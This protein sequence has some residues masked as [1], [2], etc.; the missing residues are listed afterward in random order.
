[1][2]TPAFQQLAE[3]RRQSFDKLIDLHERLSQSVDPFMRYAAGWAAMYAAQKRGS[4]DSDAAQLL[5]EERWREINGKNVSIYYG[6]DPK[7]LHVQAKLALAMSDQLRYE[8]KLWTPRERQETARRIGELAHTHLGQMTGGD[9][10]MR[11]ELAEIACLQVLWRNHTI[12]HLPILNAVPAGP[13][14]DMRTGMI[15][16]YSTDIYAYRPGSS[17]QYKGANI[18]M[19]S[20]LRPQHKDRYGDI[21]VLIGATPDFRLP[22]GGNNGSSVR[23]IAYTTETCLDETYVRDQLP[24]PDAYALNASTQNV[25]S[26]TIR[27]IRQR[28]DLSA[29]NS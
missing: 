23:R 26:K 4:G 16:A 9:A 7:I 22:G 28:N 14:K 8:R 20:T 18:Q 24:E 10:R 3:G 27:T 5:A 1:M 29:D 21:M 25:I 11:G 13:A 6:E 12:D 15:S 17:K 19:K 2:A